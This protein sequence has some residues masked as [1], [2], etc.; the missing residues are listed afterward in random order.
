MTAR[1]QRWVAILCITVVIAVLTPTVIDRLLLIRFNRAISA[2]RET[3]ITSVRFK[4]HVDRE[5]VTISDP[6]VLGQIQE[7][8]GRSKTP[9]AFYSY[10][11]TTCPLEITLA[12][13]NV[14]RFE[15]SPTGLT[16]AYIVENDIRSFERQRR[17]SYAMLSYRGYDRLLADQPFTPYLISTNQLDPAVPHPVLMYS[18]R[19]SVK[20]PELQQ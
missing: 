4:P 19:D 20:S 9:K 6:R 8:L 17:I 2:V 11:P 18:R 14:E 16:A 15:I 3:S 10:P 5:F 7:W 13:G 12:N 1:R